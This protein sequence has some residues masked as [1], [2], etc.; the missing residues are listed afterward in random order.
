[1]LQFISKK[2]EKKLEMKIPFENSL[3][4]VKNS[5]VKSLLTERVS[6]KLK[7]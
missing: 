7:W 5:I 2:S 4:R 3:T 1:M 6:E